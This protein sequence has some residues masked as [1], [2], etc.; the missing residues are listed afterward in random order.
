MA[1]KKNTSSRKASK[2]S[3]SS[4]KPPYKRKRRGDGAPIIVSGG[5]GGLTPKN[6]VEYVYAEFDD[7]DFPIM[8][9]PNQAEKLYFIHKT[10]APLY[11]LELEIGG[12]HID[13]MGFL[14]RNS[15][16]EIHCRRKRERIR[17]TTTPFGVEYHPG[18][19]K[20][21]PATP[22][23]R[24]KDGTTI[25][26]IHFNEEDSADEIVLYRNKSEVWKITAKA[27]PTKRRSK[28]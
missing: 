17:I 23:K 26:S 9:N 13:L 16:L 22:K 12:R 10:N 8:G 24:Q 1:T 18:D 6:L 11:S 15:S 27:P 21:I 7:T 4:R 19:Y 5:G 3:N 20:K 28:R 14:V 2:K 25:D